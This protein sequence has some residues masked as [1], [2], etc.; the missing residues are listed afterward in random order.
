VVHEN[1]IVHLACF[2]LCDSLVAAL[3]SFDLQFIRLHQP[4]GDIQV[5]FHVIY[6]KHV[7]V[8]HKLARDL[9]YF[10]VRQ[11]VDT[12]KPQIIRDILA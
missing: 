5:S 11:I 4:D 6:D 10:A 1:N 2:N 9:A 3:N 8:G 12:E 7:S